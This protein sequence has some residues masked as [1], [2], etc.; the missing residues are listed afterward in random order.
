MNEEELTQRIRDIACGLDIWSYAFSRYMRERLELDEDMVQFAMEHA[1][2]MDGSNVKIG[3]AKEFVI[4]GLVIYLM[5]E[6]Y[7]HCPDIQ[8]L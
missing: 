8:P 1:Q 5:D 6:V 3:G 4:Q 7:A 2:E